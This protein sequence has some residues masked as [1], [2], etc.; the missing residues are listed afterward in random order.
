MKKKFW[1]FGI[2]F[3][4]SAN[5]FAQYTVDWIFPCGDFN[6]IS[7]M[8]V[9]DKLN[10]LVIAGYRQSENM[11]TRKYGITGTFLWE[12][13]DSSGINGKYEKPL[14]VNCDSSNNVYIVGKRY[15]I[16]A[17]WEYPDAVVVAKY[18]SSGTFL[19]KQ[20][21]P[22]SVLIGSQHPG[23]NLR[24]EV[25]IDGNI[26]IGTAA[27]DPSGFVLIKIGPAGNILFT[28]NSTANAP[29]GFSSMRL[30]GN[31]V[32]MTGSSGNAGSA[33]VIAWDTS[34]ALLWTASLQ[35]Q[36]GND[37]ETDKEGNVFL[38]TSY[39]NQVNSSNG[40]DLVMYKFNSSGT[41][42]WKKDYDLGGNEFS[43]QFTLVS[44]RLSCI[45]YGSLSGY[46]DWIVIQTDTGGTRLWDNRYNATAFNDERPYSVAARTNGDVIVT[47]IGGP[48]P[49]PFN[50]SY[51]QMVILEYDSSGIQLWVDTP[52]SYGGAGLTCMFAGDNS[53][54]AAS[55]YN[56][57]AYH[58]QATPVGL[59]ND[60]GKKKTTISIFP[61]PFSTE[62]KIQ[63]FSEKEEKSVSVSILD[64]TGKCL[65]SFNFDNLPG[66]TNTIVLDLTGLTSGIYFCRIASADGVRVTKMVRE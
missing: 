48:S 14:W 4:V 65:R 34:G 21:V 42:L 58:F 55:Y 28:K 29:T 52:N 7:V 22:V 2:L 19:W 64:L 54:F 60:P 12:A 57:T 37:V 35:G 11:H 46:F 43:S 56:M 25:D 3:V 15:S 8:S 51:L 47:G 1:M 41:Q 50:L 62:T 27:A 38:L 13:V 30:K 10:N 40:Q 44:G 36:A 5:L 16:G 63:F 32:V 9:T 23:F 17:V 45:G 26:Y 49:D 59:E 18:S 20:I 61:N 31:R 53:L 39:P 33:P 24:S 66:G 6:K